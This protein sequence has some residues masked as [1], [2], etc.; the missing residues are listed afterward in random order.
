LCFACN[1]EEGEDELKGT[2]LEIISD[3]SFTLETEDNGTCI[4]NTDESTNFKDFT[5]VSEL[6]DGDEVEVEG[7]LTEDCVLLATEIELEDYEGT[8][9]G[10]YEGTDDGS[11][12]SG[13]DSGSDDDSSSGSDDDA[14]DAAEKAA[15][16]A[17][18]AAEKA[19]KEAADAAE[20]ATED[21]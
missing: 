19:A 10:T 14:A 11:G 16:D 8:D 1:S 6:M 5:G 17:A 20:E 4:I 9:E 13:S 15:K 3:T 7:T 2:I 21:D 18:D 12:N